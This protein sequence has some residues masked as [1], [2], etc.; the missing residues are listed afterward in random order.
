MAGDTEQILVTGFPDMGSG[1]G[2]HLALIRMFD[3]L[4]SRHVALYIRAS[5][6]YLNGHHLDEAFST[7][8]PV[9][10]ALRQMTK[11]DTSE[12][13]HQRAREIKAEENTVVR[14]FRQEGI[15]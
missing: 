13:L 9:L 7:V 2:I 5:D 1:P 6:W 15:R 10:P 4:W 3:Q 8:I 14:K 12:M 11:K